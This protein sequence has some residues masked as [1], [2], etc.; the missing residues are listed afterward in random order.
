MGK[1]LQSGGLL[2]LFFLWVFTMILINA[3]LAG[4]PDV[5]TLDSR[6]WRQ[7]VENGDFV[8]GLGENDPGA[9]TV[10]DEDQTVTGLLARGS[11]QEQG[12]EYSYTQ[13]TDVAEQL[14][15]ASVP[16][17]TDPQTVGFWTRTLFSIAPLLIVLLLFLFVMR[18]MQGNQS[19]RVMSLGKSR[20]R[21]MTKDQ[22]KVTFSDVAGADEAVQ[23]LTEIKEF[24]EAP[25]KFQKL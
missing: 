5:Q 12:F 1:F 11:S 21:R 3:L 18:S 4:D 19:N 8:T 9:L 10:K 16:F 20:A 6:E 24:L 23:E 7:H 22:P 2:H 15:E 25:Q 17:Y 13:L 14:D